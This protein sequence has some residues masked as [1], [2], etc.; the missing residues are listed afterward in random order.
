MGRGGWVLLSLAP[1]QECAQ[2][3]WSPILEILNR[4]LIQP[5]PHLPGIKMVKQEDKV[6][7]PS[8]AYQMMG[9]VGKI[10]GE[11]NCSWQGTVYAKAQAWEFRWQNKGMARRQP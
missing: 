2:W 3:A 10:G 1:G 11:G 4:C 6:P 8:P 5:L 9:R 7:T